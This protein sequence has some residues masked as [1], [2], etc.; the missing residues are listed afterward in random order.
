MQS[1]ATSIL[2]TALLVFA[3]PAEADRGD[4]RDRGDKPRFE[5]NYDD[6]RYYDGKR[7]KDRHYD[8]RYD[9]RHD[10]R[11]WAKKRIRIDVPVRVRGD[12]RFKLRRIA[13]RRGIDLNHYRL[14]KVVVDSHGPR[15]SW[16]RLRI[17]DKVSR[18]VRLG[19]GRTHIEAP[20]GA[21]NGRMILGVV[22]ARVSNIRMVF[23][24][25]P[26]RYAYWDKPYKGHKY[27]KRYYRPTG[28]ISLR[29]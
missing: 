22:D 26:R 24:P 12:E 17:G 19:R 28:H 9:R 15:H 5:Q 16:A 8:D 7:Y 20:R 25:K 21:Q 11:R 13:A 10:K 18:D 23:E 3:L 2:I 1:A 27:D 29:F 14:V 6:A 4:K